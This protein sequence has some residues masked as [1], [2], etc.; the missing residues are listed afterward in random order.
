MYIFFS[1]IF[2]QII[3]YLK[4]MQR[5]RTSLSKYWEICL[6]YPALFLYVFSND[7]NLIA[8]NGLVYRKT[9]LS[10][11]N[12]TICNS[13]QASS[14]ANAS[15]DVQESS[16]QT[17][18]ILNISFMIPA[19]VSL[20]HLSGIA[21]RRL[22]YELPLLASL[23]GSICQA[24]ICIFAVQSEFNLFY[25]LMIFSQIVN[26]VFGAGCLAFISSCFSHIALFEMVLAH[27]FK[28]KSSILNNIHLKLG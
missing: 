15:I 23:I 10:K 5:I 16:S 22:N 17:Q 12:E 26:A 2:I 18:I 6:I 13:I 11:Y 3:D 24:F 8:Q 28:N 19:I 7:I 1:H 27:F 20:I 4:E 21:D 25:I 9:C 14:N